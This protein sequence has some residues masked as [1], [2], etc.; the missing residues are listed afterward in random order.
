M[1][2]YLYIATDPKFIK[3][4]IQSA[5]SLKKVAP[6]SSIA[7]IVTK[8]PQEDIGIFNHV[9]V[10]PNTHK[11]ELDNSRKQILADYNLNPNFIEG[12][13]YRVEHLYFKS[14]YEET[15]YLDTD[16]YFIENCTHLFNILKHFDVCMSHTP[17]DLQQ[18]YMEGYF[19]YNTGVI[20]Y[21]KNTKNNELFSKWFEF[22]KEEVESC[23]ND[24]ASFMR[25]LAES[26]S[27][28]Y[29]LRNNYNARTVFPIQL[30]GSVKIIHGR[31]Q[32]M[33]KVVKSIN[34]DLKLRLWTPPVERRKYCL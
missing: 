18:S 19:P 3:E 6:S 29:V 34:S 13:L 16:T 12:L 8:K 2:G 28:V 4:A 26:N 17:A 5:V 31:H 27:R 9:L 33:N 21:K 30:C 23:Y 15:F 25:S 11:V 20:V 7:L 24:Q 10:Q 1:R 32:D 22:Y 14:P